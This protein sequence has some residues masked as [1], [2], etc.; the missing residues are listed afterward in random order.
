M[1]EKSRVLSFLTKDLSFKPRQ[2]K[3]VIELIEDKNTIPFIARY[4]K[5]QTDNLDEVE[6]KLIVDKYT[7]LTKLEERKSEIIRLISEQGKMTDK[8]LAQINEADKLQSLD[9]L[10][11]P[12]RQKRRTL[13]TIAKEKGLEPFAL[14]LMLQ[15]DSLDIEAE[16]KKYL[17]SEVDLNTCDDVLAGVHEIIAEIISDNPEFRA[18]FRKY[19]YNNGVIETSLKD[20]SKDER[21]VYEM[22]Y[23]HS[24]KISK[25]V[26]H[27]ALAINRAEKEDVLKVDITVNLDEVH[28]FLRNMIITNSISPAIPYVEA[29]FIDAYKRF[30]APAIERELRNEVSDNAQEQAV[31]VFSE[32]LYNLLLQAPLKDKVV[33]GFDPAYRTGC[34]LAIVDES[35]KLLKVAVIF[36]HASSKENLKKAENTFIELLNDYNVDLVAIGNGT[37]SRESEIFV[38]QNIK[39]VHKEVSYTIVNEAGASVYSASELARQEFPDLQV[40]ERSAVSIARRIQDPLAELVKVDPKSVGVGQYQHD[41]SEKVLDDQLTFVVENAVNQVGVDINSASFKLLEYISG[42]NKTVAGNIIKYRDEN[43]GFSNRNELKKVP[44]LGPKSFEQ[45]IG[46]IRIFNGTNILDATKIH[47]ESYKVANRVIKDFKLDVDNLGSSENTSKLNTIDIESLSKDYEVGYETLKDIIEALAEPLRDI[48]SDVSAPSLRSDVLTIKDLK[49]G[50]SLDGT[51]RNVVDFGA[52]VDIG[53]DN[54]GLVHIS[55]ISNKFIKHP[56]EVL[57]VGQQVKVRVLDF[58]IDKGRVQLTMKN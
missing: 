40:E 38:A 42:L 19:T 43:N 41:I 7:Y 52:F 51:V 50:L 32:N 1:N 4:R 39:H 13:A 34:K 33:M 55:E 37:A 47:P 8:L 10:Y 48:R 28:N 54:D 14:L 9:D 12:Y 6:I 31:K 44:R 57:K 18:F 17:N 26:S 22:Y 3:S 16:C 56:S 27:R 23:N 11:R 30:I 46:F 53:L 36:P 24:E 21:K 25:L 58:D 45:A 35:G 20:Q 29:G 15:P 2:I 5:E 49:L